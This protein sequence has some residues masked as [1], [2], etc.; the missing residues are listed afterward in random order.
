MA[1][2]IIKTLKDGPLENLGW[3]EI[4][5]RGGQRICRERQRAALPVP[6]RPFKNKAVLRQ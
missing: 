1:E 6:L 2:V 4:S 5:G 3:R